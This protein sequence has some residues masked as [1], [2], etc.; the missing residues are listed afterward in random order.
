[1]SVLAY[2]A[3]L[4]ISAM[5][6][7]VKTPELKLFVTYFKQISSLPKWS[8]SPG[9]PL[10]APVTAVAS[11]TIEAPGADSFY[12][13]GGKFNKKFIIINEKGGTRANPIKPF[14]VV[15]YGF[16]SKLDVCLCQAFPAY[17]NACR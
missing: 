3:T 16:S 14:A 5:S 10:T 2:G 9:Y 12:L 8:P 17:S 11:F 13:W 6:C 4:V 15:M 1:M 7:T